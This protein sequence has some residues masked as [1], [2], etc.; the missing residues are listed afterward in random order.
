MINLRPHNV[1]HQGQETKELRSEIRKILQEQFSLPND[2]LITKDIIYLIEDFLL[3]SI[4]YFFL[5]SNYIDFR[6]YLKDIN[7]KSKEYSYIFKKVNKLISLLEKDD[8]YSKKKILGDIH[9]NNSTKYLL[10]KK[11]QYTKYPDYSS[12]LEIISKE[13]LP[14]YTSFFP[15][16]E[17]LRDRTICRE[18]VDINL[19]S[20]NGDVIN[21]YYYNLGRSIPLLLLL[22]AIDINAENML[23]KLPYPIFFDMEPIFSGEFEEK[24]KGYSIKSTGVIRLSSIDD[25][26]ILF[27]GLGIRYSYLK[28]NIFEYKGNPY[29]KWKVPSYENFN[30]IPRLNGKEVNPIDYTKYLMSG[31][32]DSASMVLKKKDILPSLIQDIDT[33]TRVIART[34]KVYRTLILESIY[35]QIY[36]KKDIRGFLKEKLSKQSFLYEF[37]NINIENEEIEAMM[38]LSVPVFYSNIHSKDIFTHDEKIVGQYNTTQFEYWE[39]YLKETINQSFF[40]EQ[41]ELIRESNY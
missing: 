9:P 34:T 37:N 33:Y 16:I 27:A 23:V 20:N 15:N 7:L 28:P 32:H 10:D 40:K 17:Q 22:R 31:Y 38:N 36:L 12:A 2:L 3:P 26:S 29:I 6:K 8:I 19:K 35:P 21:Q 30:N 41:E 25:Y 18:Y 13:I 4:V 5:E 14:D 1:V 11:V 24:V 39:K